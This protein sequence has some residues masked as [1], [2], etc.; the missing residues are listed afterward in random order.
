M[1][2]QLNKEGDVRK[3][4]SLTQKIEVWGLD[5]VKRVKGNSIFYDLLFVLLIF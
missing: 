5:R 2:R 1:N 4:M 3:L